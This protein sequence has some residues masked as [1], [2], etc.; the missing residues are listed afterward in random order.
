MAIRDRSPGQLFKTTL[1]FFSFLIESDMFQP[2]HSR[3]RG[4]SLVEALTLLC[5]ALMVFG[6][7]LPIIQKMREQSRR[8]N[9]EKNLKQLGLAIHNYHSQHKS[10]PI[11]GTGPTNESNND[12]CGAALQPG[13][14]PDTPAFS[15][16][17]LSYLVGLLPFCEQQKLWEQISSPHVDRSG[18]A[19]PA[20]GPPP[21]SPLYDA[22]N[23]EIPLFRCPSDPGSG[24]PSLGRTNYACSVGDSA[25]RTDDQSWS[26]FKRSGWRYNGGNRLRAKQVNRSVRGMFVPRRQMKF[27]DVDD[28]LS[29]TICLTEIATDLGDNDI[30]TGPS[31]ING[32]ENVLRNPRHCRDSG[33]IDSEAPGFWRVDH[34]SESAPQLAVDMTRRGFR[35][36]DFRPLYTQVNTILPPNSELCLRGTHAQDGIVPP[37]SRH[38]GGVHVLM[39]DGAVI[40]ITDSIEA[41]D[42]HATIVYYRDNVHQHVPDTVQSPFGL[43]GALGTRSSKENLGG[44][45]EYG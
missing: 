28:G 16:H 8:R 7:T 3:R 26:Y 12:C 5:A 34:D 24:S 20:F 38:P 33:Q 15:R 18:H 19:W 10:L 21:Y 9:C 36:A 27:G 25:W 6:L 41:G 40:F 1:S 44:S 32:R 43:W 29:N 14:F 42:E 4:V 13:V 17:Q 22:W 39:G 37:S 11:H 30:R 23:T 45:S 31:L 35:W 2:S